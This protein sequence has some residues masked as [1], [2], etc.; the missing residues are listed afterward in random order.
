ME[1]TI[2]KV[3][4]LQRLEMFADIPSEQLAQ[5]AD[6]CKEVHYAAGE[7]IYAKDDAAT[8][9]YIL[10][11]GEVKITR[12]GNVTKKIGKDEAL[13]VWG[14]FD[15][16]PRLYTAK[17]LKDSYLLKL[18]STDFFDLIEDRIRVS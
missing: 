7:V 9:M 11:D 3:I 6:L 14:C 18:D 17:A 8:A 1:T 15:R 16:S 2:I 5:I 13:G 12:E 4:H 10:I